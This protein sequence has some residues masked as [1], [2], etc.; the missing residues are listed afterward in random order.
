MFGIGVGLDNI[1]GQGL[2]YRNENLSIQLETG[3]TADNPHS[4]FLF[5]RSRQTLVFNQNGVQVIV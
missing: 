1:S 2:D 3:L 4:A 5:V